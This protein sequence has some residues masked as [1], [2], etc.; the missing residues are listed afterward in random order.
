M[1]IS[2]DRLSYD[3]F[4]LF[5]RT[6]YSLKACGLNNGDGSAEANWRGF[7]EEVES[8]IRNPS[9]QKLV[10]AVDLI[11]TNPPKKQIIENGLIKWIPATPSTQLFAD[12]LFIYIRRVRNNLFHGGKF[13]GHWFAPERSKNLMQ[14]SIIILESCIDHVERV[15]EAFNG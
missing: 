11:M 5:S 9:S 3:F 15:S 7:A 13:N 4:Y 2:L 6:E 1:H 12:E 14:S 8:L 10:N